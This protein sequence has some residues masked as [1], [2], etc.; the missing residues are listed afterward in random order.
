MTR[1]RGHWWTLFA[2]ITVLSGCAAP[3]ATAPA[4]AVNG[5]GDTNPVD[6]SLLAD[7]GNLRWPVQTYPANFNGLHIDS[8]AGGVAQ[9]ADAVMPQLVRTAADGSIA[10][11]PDYLTSFTLVSTSPQVV[12]YKLNPR[13]RWSDGTPITWVD[14]RSQWQALNLRDP[15][16]RPL[17]STGYAEIADVAK[18]ADE[19]EA[20]VTFAIPF[21][22]WT[23]L[24]QDL[25]PASLTRDPEVFNTGWREKPAVTAGPFRLAQLDPVARTV[26]V[27]RDPNWWGRRPRLERITFRAMATHA[28]T[29][30]LENGDID[31]TEI[32]GDINKFQRVTSMQG[33]EVRRTVAS[34]VQEIQFNGAPGAILADRELRKALMRG[35]DRA[36]IA[37]ALTGQ[38]VPTAAPSG[39]H[40]YPVGLRGYRDNSAVVAYDP[41]AAA[42]RL[43]ELGWK[44]DGDGKRRKDGKELVIRDVT[45]DDWRRQEALLVQ[46]QLGQLGVR[47]EIDTV[48]LNDF[49]AKY[50]NKGDFDVAHIGRGMVPSSPI[51]YTAPFYMRVAATQMNYGRMGNDYI[52]QLYERAKRE[53][54]ENKRIALANEIDRAVW[55]EG[56]SLPLYGRPWVYGVRAKLANIGASVATDD[57]TAVGFVK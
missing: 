57:L 27:E 13:A 14:V 36:T 56:F 31:L 20:V 48:P 43:D 49:F 55:D 35:I 51:Y 22:E 1:S 4:R 17:R 3:G 44:R 9:V 18:G 46:N 41:A 7:G 38:I 54:D 25:Y 19:F 16:Y 33:V 47:V 15:G 2:L 28:E 42:R 21:A 11:N 53:L 45:P 6:P 26:I 23:P 29:D 39:N 50:V 10:P 52:N 5:A 8:N 40:L 34:A 30:A 24:F 12:S 37:T 32:A